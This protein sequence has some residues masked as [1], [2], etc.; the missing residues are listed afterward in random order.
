M[1][2]II[3]I[4][5]GFSVLQSCKSTA[6]L[7]VPDAFEK[8]ST[9]MRVKGSKSTGINHEISFGNYQSSGIKRGWVFPKEKNLNKF[10]FEN[11][12]LALFGLEKSDVIATQ[13]EKFHYTLA[14]ETDKLNIYCSRKIVTEETRYREPILREMQKRREGFKRSYTK[15]EDYLFEALLFNGDTVIVKPWKLVIRSYVDGPGLKISSNGI[16]INVANEDGFITNYTDTVG[17]R[18]IFTSKSVDRNNATTSVSFRLRT[19]YE[20]RMG[21]GVVAIVDIISHS[22]WLFNGLTSEEKLRL[23]AAAS[24]ILINSSITKK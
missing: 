21:D 17:I 9:F 4:S 1:Y 14:N 19:G 18:E 24:A 15:S 13:Q 23:S 5:V 11:R 12:L 7:R 2:L 20:F 22:I 10:G 6:L 16:K 3:I 8:K